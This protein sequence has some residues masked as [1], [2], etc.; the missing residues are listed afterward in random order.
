MRRHLKKA[1]VHSYNTAIV[2][3]ICGVAFTLTVAIAMKVGGNHAGNHAGN[4][5]CVSAA[6]APK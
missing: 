4:A 2:A 1:A 3:L 5:C 6:T